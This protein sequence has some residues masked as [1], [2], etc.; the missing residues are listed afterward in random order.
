[1]IAQ[2]MPATKPKRIFLSPS[3]R[4]CGESHYRATLSDE[5]VLEMRAVWHKWVAAGQAGRPGAPKGY[6]A[7]EAMFG[8][9]KWTCRDIVMYRT[10]INAKG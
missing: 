1:M 10:R 7:L 3:G 8:V 6:G 4:R 5:K 9:S 2:A